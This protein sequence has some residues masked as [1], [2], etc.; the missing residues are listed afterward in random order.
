MPSL[1]SLQ[2]A[3]RL[4][5][6]LSRCSAGTTVVAKLYS[7]GYDRCH[8]PHLRRTFSTVGRLTDE[9]DGSLC[10]FEKYSDDRSIS[11]RT[12]ISSASGIYEVSRAS[13]HGTH[14]AYRGSHCARGTPASRCSKP[15]PGWDSGTVESRLNTSSRC[16]YA[17]KGLNT[18]LSHSS[19]IRTCFYTGYSESESWKHIRA[20]DSPCS[21]TGRCHPALVSSISLR[22]LM[23]IDAPGPTARFAS[24]AIL[25]RNIVSCELMLVL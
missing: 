17:K 21:N 7:I 25:L 15:A 8:E 19:D 4:V 3:P 16:T 12:I 6:P 10:D 11:I 9:S 14:S 22:S 20:H 5:R 1:G 2:A 23:V 24:G 18:L 13:D